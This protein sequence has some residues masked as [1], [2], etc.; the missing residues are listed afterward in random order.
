MSVQGQ[1]ENI[2]AALYVVL[3]ITGKSADKKMEGKKK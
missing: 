1:R 2:K 3:Q